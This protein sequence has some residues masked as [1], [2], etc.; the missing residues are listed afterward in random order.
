[1]DGRDIRPAAAGELPGLARLWHDAWHE[2]HA[3]HVPEA[4]IRHRDHGD[5][6]DRIAR[7]GDRL[8]VA[9]PLG[10]PQGLCAIGGDMIDQ[11]FVAPAARGTG[12][13][14]RLLADGEARLRLSGVSL[15]RLYCIEGN[16]R[17]VRFYRKHGW[18]GAAAER[19]SVRTGAGRCELHPLV[20]RKP[21]T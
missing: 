6:F 21:L 13:A 15:A 8:R 19:V 10:A 17:A 3:G 9:G 4:L 14:A 16:A 2:S 5:F 7:L 11:L 20:L 12:L 18:T 1:M